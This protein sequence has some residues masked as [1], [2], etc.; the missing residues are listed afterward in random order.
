MTGDIHRDW[1]PYAV[2]VV[3]AIAAT[4][5]FWYFGT[6]WADEPGVDHVRAQ[7][8]TAATGIFMTG[9]RN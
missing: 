7:T 4:V 8:C 2:A 3:V 1:I 9:T 5:G 6:C